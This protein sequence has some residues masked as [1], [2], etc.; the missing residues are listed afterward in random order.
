MGP[1]GHGEWWLIQRSDSRTCSEPWT[2]VRKNFRYTLLFSF[3]FWRWGLLW[4]TDAP[5]KLSSLPIFIMAWHHNGTSPKAKFQS[6]QRRL[7]IEMTS[8]GSFLRSGSTGNVGVT[9]LHG[10]TCPSNEVSGNDYTRTVLQEWKHSL[11]HKPSVFSFAFPK[12]IAQDE[13]ES[14]CPAQPWVP[15]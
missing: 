5:S 7:M 13:L 11:K 15:Y 1:R 2:E 10:E 3:W 6:L 12:D 8:A 9:Q 14:V 4:R